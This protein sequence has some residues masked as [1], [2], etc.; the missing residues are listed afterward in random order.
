MSER[1]PELGLGLVVSVDH[2]SRRV[3]LDFPAT[4]ERRLYA[5][6]TP[7]LKRVEFRPG[8]SITMR[9]GKTFV[10]ESVEDEAGVLVYVGQ[11]RRAREDAISD[12][13]SVSL[14]QERLMAG[15]VDPGEVFDLRY[16]ALQAQA[17]FRQSDVRGFLGGRL[18]LIPHQFYILHEVSGRQIPRVLL[19]DEVGLGKT[20]EACLILQ[21][22]LAIGRVQ[23]VLILVPESLTHQWFVELLRRFNLW[24]SIYDEERCVAVERGVSGGQRGSSRSSGG[25]GLGHCCGR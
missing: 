22:L 16:R 14:P 18:E 23:R 11:N 13:T 9:E 15:Q 10:I 25:G 19:A 5:L 8:E 20:I 4:G 2:A 3:A 7:V 21:R 12:V 24:F 17:R 6:G 1:E